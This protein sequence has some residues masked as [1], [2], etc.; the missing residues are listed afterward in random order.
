MLSS[1]KISALKCVLNSGFHCNLF[2][3]EEYKV[4]STNVKNKVLIKVFKKQ[5]GIGQVSV[6]QI[7]SQIAGR[8]VCLK[9][10]G[11]IIPI[12][13]IFCFSQAHVHVELI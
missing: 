1:S 10:S 6:G 11:E 5:D 8:N 7:A 9:K 4:Q 3:F 12:L 2:Q 13:E